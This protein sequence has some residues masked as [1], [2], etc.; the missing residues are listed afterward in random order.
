[1][2]LIKA[3]FVSKAASES[4]DSEHWV[5]VVSYDNTHPTTENVISHTVIYIKT[6]RNGGQEYYYFSLLPIDEFDRP[7]EV[8][9]LEKDLSLEDRCLWYIDRETLPKD[10]V[11][12]IP[13]CH[14][15]SNVRHFRI[16]PL[17]NDNY[18]LYFYQGFYADSFTK[19]DAHSSIQFWMPKKR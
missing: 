12:T 3:A 8:G 1:M 19:N 14:I 9:V 7:I 10:L 13:R 5:P 4:N 15:P 11:R 18:G 2:D 6:V 17:G 16:Y